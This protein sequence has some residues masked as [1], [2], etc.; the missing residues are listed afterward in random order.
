VLRPTFLEQSPNQSPIDAA[1][2]T[3]LALASRY[4]SKESILADRIL[5]STE[6]L[7]LRKEALLV[8]LEETLTEAM[9]EIWPEAQRSALR[10]SAM[11]AMGAL[12]IAKENWRENDG[13]RPL[14][15][16]IEQAFEAYR[17]LDSVAAG[18]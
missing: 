9:C 18:T 5:R 3:F 11:I 1:R 14:A 2:A 16:Y 7:R 17:R 8:Q 4:E 15:H 13:A 10:M 12:R 6:P